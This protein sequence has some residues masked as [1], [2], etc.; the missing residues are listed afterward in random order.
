[1]LAVTLYAITREQ[2]PD[3]AMLALTFASPRA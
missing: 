2:D 1:V 3:L